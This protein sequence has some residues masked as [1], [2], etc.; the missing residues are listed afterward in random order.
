[1]KQNASSFTTF[2]FAN[3]IHFTSFKDFD[4][5][6]NL[7]VKPCDKGDTQK[8]RSHTFAKKKITMFKCV[9][10]HVKQNLQCTV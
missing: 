7:Y 1:M 4:E 8:R 10:L 5:V 9:S 6:G 2:A 3:S